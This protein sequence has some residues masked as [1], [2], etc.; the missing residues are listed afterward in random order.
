MLR[1]IRA[2]EIDSG[3]A[4]V[5]EQVR[6]ALRMCPKLVPCISLARCDCGGH[7][8]DS[9]EAEMNLLEKVGIALNRRHSGGLQV[10][11]LEAHTE[12]LD[13]F[14]ADTEGHRSREHLPDLVFVLSAHGANKGLTHRSFSKIETVEA[15]D[16]SALAANHALLHHA[17]VLTRANAHHI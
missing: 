11:I 5:H 9:V 16:T 13:A 1:R 3:P 12:Q 6:Q 8:F 4:Q 7:G 17:R 15:E 2:R 10:H 14:V